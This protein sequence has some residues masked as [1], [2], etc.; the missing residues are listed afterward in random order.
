MR[1]CQEK[2]VHVLLLVVRFA[3][4]N[5][6]DDFALV[7]FQMA[8][9]TLQTIAMCHCQKKVVH[10]LLFVVWFAI[11]NESDYFTLVAFQMA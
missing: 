9:P 10:M 8:R 11:L 3:I 5:A 2:V 1:H 4:L 6:N 7:A